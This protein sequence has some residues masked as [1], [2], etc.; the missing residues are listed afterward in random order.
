MLTNIFDYIRG[1]I[2]RRYSADD[3]SKSYYFPPGLQAGTPGSFA[4]APTVVSDGSTTN[5]GIGSYPIIADIL[6]HFWAV[7]PGETSPA[8]QTTDAALYPT[9]NTPVGPTNITRTI[10]MNLVLNLVNMERTGGTRSPQ[11]QMRVS[12]DSWTI[13]NGSRS[14]IDAAVSTNASITSTNIGFPTTGGAVMRDYNFKYSDRGVNFQGGYIGLG[15]QYRGSSDLTETAHLKT[16]TF[17]RTPGAGNFTFYSDP[18]H[19]SIPIGDITTGGLVTRTNYSNENI[20]PAMMK[21]SGGAITIE[22][23]PGMPKGSSNE[24]ESYDITAN[25][26]VQTYT[27]NIPACE[28]P[29]PLLGDTSFYRGFTSATGSIETGSGT[30]FYDFGSWSNRGKY[31]DLPTFIRVKEVN[32]PYGLSS[33]GTNPWFMDVVRGITLDPDAVHKGDFRVLASTRN[34]PSGWYKSEYTT[35]GLQTNPVLSTLI[36]NSRGDNSYR[37][38][39][40]QHG[41]PVINQT[42]SIG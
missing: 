22:V 3:P 29:V 10:Q 41:C 24:S 7:K 16:K 23:F 20:D 35:N 32:Y 28:L 1:F 21:F 9:T 14:G 19:L 6:L 26:P 31:V 34:I 8:S 30:R 33:V 12:G 2:N 27:I 5:K 15:S 25:P 38:F 40:N 39:K 18:I 13:S 42:E 36:L 17:S 37:L 4:P 11:Y